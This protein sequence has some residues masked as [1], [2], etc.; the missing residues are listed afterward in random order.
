MEN[1]EQTLPSAA[2]QK[3]FQLIRI[4]FATIGIGPSSAMRPMALNWRLFMGAFIMGLYAFCNFEFIFYEAETFT[5]YTRSICAESAAIFIIFHL[6]FV[7]LD[8]ENLFD[9][10]NDCENLVNESESHKF[11]WISI[12][13]S[14]IT[15]YLALKQSAMTAILSEAIQFEQQ[16]SEIIYFI[17]AKMS[18]VGV[19]ILWIIYTYFMYSIQDLETDAF[20]LPLPIWWMFVYKI[21]FKG[22]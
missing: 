19:F 5:D 18:P 11:K 16:L 15:F 12:L 14:I 9:L 21:H 17:M 4:K 22:N 7:A 10:M 2:K 13:S 8:T 6:F 20:D 3:I 1:F